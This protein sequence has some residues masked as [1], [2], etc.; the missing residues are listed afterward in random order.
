M[1][2]LK[3]D[4][5]ISYR[6]GGMDQYVAEQIHKRLETYKLPANIVRDKKKKGEKTKI[7][8]VFRDQEELPLSDNLED[9]IVKALENSENL[10]VVCSPRFKESRWCMKEVE[11]FIKLHGRNHVYAVLVEGE[12]RESFPHQLTI[13]DKGESVEPLAADFRS[14]NKRELNKLMDMEMLRLLAPI[15]NLNFDDLRQRHRERKT[16]AIFR[17]SM[18]VAVLAIAFGSFCGFTAIK[19]A[20]QNEI[21]MQQ[22]DDITKQS[23]E[24]SSQNE[25]IEEQYEK[26]LYD[27]AIALAKESETL[28]KNGDRIKAVETA[29]AALTD[30]NGND[31]PFTEEAQ[32]ALAKALLV[33]DPGSRYTAAYKLPTYGVVL[34]YKVAPGGDYALLIDSTNTLFVYDVV[35]CKKIYEDTHISADTYVHDTA[36]F[37]GPNKIGYITDSSDF[38]VVDIVTGTKERYDVVNRDII[39]S[40]Y[41]SDKYIAVDNDRVL[42]IYDASDM[43]VV[44]SSKCSIDEIGLMCNGVFFDESSDSC[45]VYY[46]DFFDSFGN[47]QIFDM[48][49]FE[50]VIDIEARYSN[51]QS[52][53]FDEENIYVKATA[54]DVTSTVNYLVCYD[55][56]TGELK[57]EHSIYNATTEYMLDCGNYIALNNGYSL[58]IYD[59]LTGESQNIIIFEKKCVFAT[60]VG[61]TN[62]IYFTDEGLQSNF[63][64]DKNEEGSFAFQKFNDNGFDEMKLCNAGFLVKKDFADGITF[65]KYNVPLDYQPYTKT[66]FSMHYCTSVEGDEAIEIAKDYGLANYFITD[67]IVYSEKYDWVVVQYSNK[68]IDIFD[69]KKKVITDH[70]DDVPIIAGNEG[71]DI[72]GLE[73]LDASYTGLAINK[74]G[75]IEFVIPEFIGLS[76]DGEKISILGSFGDDYNAA[77]FPIYSKDQLLRIAEATIEMYAH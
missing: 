56:K 29:Y 65:Y 40:V 49:T 64:L 11:T 42:Q 32:R 14:K 26:V 18:L 39:A 72:N 27:Q 9:V 71:F 13:N 45:M 37:I 31:M 60:L 22:N 69:T 44:L 47:L 67:R 59:K 63:Y 20:K 16:K 28:Y 41:S 7:E 21:I 70:M 30:Y 48:N 19:M 36:V 57:W 74:N 38:W 75:K 55:K 68:Q 34:D 61:D 35:N 73:Y 17:I 23:I 24:I 53:L 54:Y 51:V 1:E 33:Y 43:S 8:R 10:I 3:Y 15:F 66:D 25:I 2:N 76:D 12:P 62:L 46:G 4:A 77:Y 52:C 50:K 58:A 5:F 6:H